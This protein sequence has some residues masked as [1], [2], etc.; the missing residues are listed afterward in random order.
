MAGAGNTQGVS[1][2]GSYLTTIPGVIPLAQSAVPSYQLTGVTTQT[3]LDTINLTFPQGLNIGPDSELIV[4]V[5]WSCNSSANTKNL[6]CM[7]GDIGAVAFLPASDAQTTNISNEWL[8]RIGFRN[9]LQSQVI[10]NLTPSPTTT[11]LQT[12]A[13]QLHR[14]GIPGQLLQMTF[15]GTLANAADNMRIERYSVWLA[16]A[17]TNSSTRA[18]YGQ[19]TFWGGNAHFDDITPGGGGITP[20]QVINC[21]NAMGMTVIRMAW[22]G[23]DFSL[24]AL[25]QMAIA[26]QGTGIQMYCCIDISL[27]DANSV[28]WKDEATAFAYAWGAT[29]KIVNTLKPYGVVMYEAGNELDTKFNMDAAGATGYYQYYFNNAQWPIFRGAIG[30]CVAAIQQLG[31]LAASNAFTVCGV[32]GMDMLWNGTAPDG[33]GGY[34]KVRWD[35]SAFHNYQPYGPLTSI[36]TFVGGP[37]VNVLQYMA[38]AYNRP[39]MISE[40][41]GAAGNTGAQNATYLDRTMRECYALRYKYNIMGYI[42]YQLFQGTPWGVINDPSVASVISPMGTT[43][44]NLIKNVL[45]DTGN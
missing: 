28:F 12:P 42:I 11:A 19:K 22:E 7:F 5:T 24:N 31:C 14:D 30:G 29:W 32:G 33:S 2:T 25:K 23:T 34:P 43:A 16:N 35:I 20:A 18:L 39:I 9:N 15:W 36:Q 6:A 4:S 40:I 37:Y 8:F 3:V 21:C 38:N 1:T 44:Q 13:Y 17:P 41:N 45:P 27:Q 26:L 10:T